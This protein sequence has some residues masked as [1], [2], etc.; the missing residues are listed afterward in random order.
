MPTQ[1]RYEPHHATN[2]NELDFDLIYLVFYL[3]RRKEVILFLYFAVK[4]GF[5][6]QNETSKNTAR[7]T[8]SDLVL[9]LIAYIDL[10]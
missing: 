9:N 2:S 1:M 7:Q 10:V 6:G 5:H 3:K 4:N 8:I